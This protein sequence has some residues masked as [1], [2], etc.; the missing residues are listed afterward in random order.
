MSAVARALLLLLFIVVMLPV[1][2]MSAM[3]SYDLERVLSNE[4]STYVHKNLNLL[5]SWCFAVS[6]ALK[7]DISTLLGL[8]DGL[9]V[10]S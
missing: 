1:E 10:E 2:A 4:L 5:W 7:F 9:F 3:N 8:N 6:S